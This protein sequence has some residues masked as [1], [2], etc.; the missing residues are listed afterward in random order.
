MSYQFCHPYMFL[1]YTMVIFLSSTECDGCF[2]DSIHSN[3]LSTGLS[4]LINLINANTVVIIIVIT[5]TQAH[6]IK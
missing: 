2:T 3:A 1:G 6:L 5:D 4:K